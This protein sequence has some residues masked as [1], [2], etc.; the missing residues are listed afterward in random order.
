MTCSGLEVTAP[1]NCTGLSDDHPQASD[2]GVPATQGQES[3]KKRKK[4]NCPDTEIGPQRKGGSAIGWEGDSSPWQVLYLDN[5][6]LH[7]RHSKSQ[8]VQ[9]L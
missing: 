1:K 5:S 6:S 8:S 2:A 4:E 3:V 7:Q 9:I